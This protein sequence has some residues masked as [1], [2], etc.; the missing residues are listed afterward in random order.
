MAKCNLRIMS[1]IKKKGGG[2]WRGKKKGD[3]MLMR[4][5]EGER[6]RM[7]QESSQID[8]PPRVYYNRGMLILGLRWRVRRKKER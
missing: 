7:S 6:R 4:Q 2:G 3:Q 5:M 1:F 8:V